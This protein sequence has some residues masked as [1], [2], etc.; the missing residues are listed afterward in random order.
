M[1]TA[2]APIRNRFGGC[3]VSAFCRLRDWFHRIRFSG[4]FGSPLAFIAAESCARRS[5]ERSSFLFGLFGTR[6]LA[7]A[8]SAAAARAADFLAALNAFAASAASNRRFSSA[9]LAG[10]SRRRFSSRLIFFLKPF[11]FMIP[12]ALVFVVSRGVNAHIDLVLS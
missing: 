4:S 9:N 1:A 5:G 7:S 3:N 10:P 12:L 11:I 8:I 6:I 2:D